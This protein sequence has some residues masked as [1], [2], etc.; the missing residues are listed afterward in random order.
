MILDILTTQHSKIREN[1]L[2]LYVIL[3]H[4]LSVLHKYCIKYSIAYG[5][6]LAQVRHKN[7]LIWEYDVDLILES[8]HIFESQHIWKE[9]YDKGIAILITPYEQGYSA[10]YRLV[11]HKDLNETPP[12]HPI[13]AG[14]NYNYPKQMLDLHTASYINKCYPKMRL[15]LNNLESCKLGPL[16]TFRVKDYVGVLNYSYTSSCIHEV[17]VDHN[18]DFIP[19]AIIPYKLTETDIDDMNKFYESS[20]YNITLEYIIEHSD[21]LL[22]GVNG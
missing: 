1:H 7:I 17:I 3:F 10:L 22:N 15:N 19:N 18:N 21:K 14:L 2:D 11:L 20:E 6:L 16:N 5:T 12:M 9:L 13:M 8:D 4:T